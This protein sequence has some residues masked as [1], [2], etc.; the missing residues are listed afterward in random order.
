MPRRNHLAGSVTFTDAEVEAIQQELIGI[1]TD[2][3]DLDIGIANRITD[4]LTRLG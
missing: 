3:A 4:V 1:R 2:A